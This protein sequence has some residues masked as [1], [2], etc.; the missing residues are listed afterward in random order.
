[1]KFRTKLILFTST[2]IILLTTISIYIISNH[3]IQSRL[4]VAISNTI[5]ETNQ[6][7]MMVESVIYIDESLSLEQAK[8]LIYRNNKTD[9]FYELQMENEVSKEILN[10]YRTDSVYKLETRNDYY[11]IEAYIPLNILG[12]AYVLRGKHNITSLIEESDYSQQFIFISSG[13]MM[14]LVIILSTIFASNMTKNIKKLEE[15]TS[16]MTR[17]EYNQQVKINSNDEIKA[18]GDSFNQM[19]KTTNDLIERLNQTAQKN[20]QLY[21][22]L[23]HEINTP[24]TSIIGYSELLLNQPYEENLYNRSLTHIFQEGKRLSVLSENLLALSNEKLSRKL[25]SIKELL[26]KSIKT[27][28]SNIRKDI[29]FEIS[30][31]DF[32]VSIDQNLMLAVIV[33][34]IN[35][36]V[37]SINNKGQITCLMKKNQLIIKDTGVGISKEKLQVLFDPFY[38]GSDDSKHLGLGLTLVKDIMD[39]HGDDV[40]IKSNKNGTTVTLSYTTSLQLEENSDV[41]TSYN[42]TKEGIQ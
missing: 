11:Y 3:L 6:V 22:A 16:A 40:F 27:C 36:A 12:K 25:S 8:N 2:F 26:E 5:G 24:L 18:L 29:T 37:H 38:K 7:K 21:G 32:D 4:E 20:K 30:G 10:H 13:I 42:E 23:T 15:A 9:V 17:G 34:L 28:Q 14:V 1:M 41:L 19:S 35:N 39:L 31:G 33:N